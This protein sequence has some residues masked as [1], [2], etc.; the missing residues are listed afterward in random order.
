MTKAPKWSDPFSPEGTREATSKILTG[1]NYRL[2]Y[3]EATRQKI[4]STCQELAELA[5]K[6]PDNNEAWQK[7]IHE[8][9]AKK[10][11]E[12]RQLQSWLIGLTKKTAENLG[13]KID[14]YPAMFD[15]LVADLKAK[16][17]PE[18][19]DIALLLWSGSATLTIRG[20]QKSKIGKSLER[21]LAAAALTTIGLEQDRGDFRLNVSAD[22]EVARET[23]AEVKTPRGFVRMEVGLIGKGNSEVISDKVGRMNRNGV[24][25]MDTL[26]PKSTAYETAKQNGVKLIQIRN[27]HPVEELRLH[28]ASLKVINVQQD[29]IKL[30][31][32]EQRILKMPLAMFA[33]L[34][35]DK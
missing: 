27:G 12:E 26:P 22:E 35:E 13:V 32:V 34:P 1:K 8:I 14:D 7:H 5:K 21:S 23:D 28:L 6:H 11:S 31:E 15:D 16:H 29:P 18:F 17:G 9:L 19:R 25:L 33:K 30:E 10:S 20:S 2:F 3:E 24:I 4:I